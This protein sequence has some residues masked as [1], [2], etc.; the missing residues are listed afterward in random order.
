MSRRLVS[1]GW[2]MKFLPLSSSSFKSG[3]SRG[4]YPW[5][6]HNGP[7]GLTTQKL[8]ID[9]DHLAQWIKQTAPGWA[10]GLDLTPLLALSVEAAQ[11]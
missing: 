6:T 3:K 2:G 9:V 1:L 8:W 7:S 4:R 10:F 11:G 5:L